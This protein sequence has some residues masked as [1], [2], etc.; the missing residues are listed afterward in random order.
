MIACLRR[1]L[2]VADLTVGDTAY[3]VIE[4]G[5][6]RRRRDVRLIA[7]L[8]LDARLFTPA[9]ER[10]PGTVSRAIACPTSTSSW[11]TRSRRGLRPQCGGKTGPLAPWIFGHPS[12]TPPV[13][14][15]RGHNSTACSTRSAMPTDPYKVELS[16]RQDPT[17][18]LRRDG[19]T[20]PKSVSRFPSAI[21]GV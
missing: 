1:W 13:R 15:S 4:L 8:R 21:F 3:S 10:A 18:H 2:P 19:V 7:A 16:R 14:K 6:A 12:V 20:R 5:L 17:L 9:P 11:P